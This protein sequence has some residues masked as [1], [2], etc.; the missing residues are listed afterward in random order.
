MLFHR[1]IAGQL[2]CQTRLQQLPYIAVKA[3]NY[4]VLESPSLFHKRMLEL[5]KNARHRIMMTVLYLQDDDC[6]R[7]DRK[8]VV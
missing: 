5:I 1:N 8:S 6:G 4:N 3:E 2:Y 7:E